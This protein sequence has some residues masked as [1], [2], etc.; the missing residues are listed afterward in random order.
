MRQGETAVVRNVNSV[1]DDGLSGGER[2][3]N[4]HGMRKCDVYGIGQ[5]EQLIIRL[6]DGVYH[7]VVVVH[8][9]VL[10]MM[11]KN[12]HNHE[13]VGHRIANTEHND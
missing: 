10:R 7:L 3:G 13:G 11:G 1:D 6:D 12:R 4:L 2:N 9:R 8:L 5:E